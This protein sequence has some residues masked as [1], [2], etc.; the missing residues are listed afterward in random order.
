MPDKY[1]VAKF[2]QY[3]RRLAAR[4][5]DQHF[6]STPAATLDGP[7]LLAFT[8]VRQLNLLVVRQLLQAWQA[9]TSRLRSPY[10]D[11][12]APAVQA[13]LQE[14]QNTLSRYIKL[15]R[16][17]LEPLLAQAVAHTILLAASPAAAFQQLLAGQKPL[18]LADFQQSLR[19]VVLNKEFLERFLTTLP[20][21]ENL[22]PDDV[23]QQLQAYEQAHY[24]EHQPLSQLVDAL[25]PLLPITEAD[26]REAGPVSAVPPAG[27]PPSAL[28]PDIDVPAVTAGMPP[29]LVAQEPIPLP[30][31]PVAATEPL[32]PA[33]STASNELPAPASP[34]LH[35]KL[36]AAQP[37][38]TALAATLRAAQFQP[39]VLGERGATKIETLRAAISINLRFSFINELFNGENMEYHA[40]IQHLDSLTDL[41]QA[42]EYV[43]HNLAQRYDWTRK[44][45]HVAKLLKLVER[46][47]DPAHS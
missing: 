10:F 20:Q 35:E 39:P 31:A 5:C 30:P 25:S 27:L 9:E 28:T 1:S 33:R 38:G 46:K 15:D 4:L 13:A 17:A 11:F 32:P 18:I 22:L 12:E 45:E 26:L 43:T 8:P 24:R 41:E 40:A 16:T 44:E 42:R 47:L 37:T 3:G 6:A 23:W 21:Q 36:K 34:P 7:A 2:E 29:A 19:Y 14:F